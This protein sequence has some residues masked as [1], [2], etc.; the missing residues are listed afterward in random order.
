MPAWDKSEAGPVRPAGSAEEETA[1]RR[2]SA[3]AMEARGVKTD[4]L[5]WREGVRH[6]NLYIMCERENKRVIIYKYK[7]IRF[8]QGESERMRESERRKG[9]SEGGGVSLAQT[10]PFAPILSLGSGQLGGREREIDGG[11][12][13]P[14]HWVDERVRER[15]SEGEREK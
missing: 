12:G 2:A 9:E 3:A 5:P 7:K 13:G 10:H 1:R 8:F 4:G 11:G 15:E 6:I 14:V